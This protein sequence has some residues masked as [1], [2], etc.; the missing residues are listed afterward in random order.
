MWNWLF[1]KKEQAKLLYL[2][3]EGIVEKEPWFHEIH[4]G[5]YA[6]GDVR[7]FLLSFSSREDYI[8]FFDK[9]NDSN[10]DFHHFFFNEPSVDFLRQV[11]VVVAFS[12]GKDL[13]EVSK[14]YPTYFPNYT[15][16]KK[17]EELLSC[18][19][20]DFIKHLSLLK[21]EDTE[22]ARQKVLEIIKEVL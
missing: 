9:F 4:Y 8:T 1:G 15:A 17:R 11:Q 12:E 14:L 18:G 22:L 5:K 19:K 6:E 16:K 10:K 3:E 13:D 21:Q 20:E 7:K 2:T